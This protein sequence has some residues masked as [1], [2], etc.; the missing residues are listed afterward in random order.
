M[1][2]LMLIASIAMIGTGVFCVANGSVA[3]LTVAFVIGLMFCVMGALETVIGTRA[4][5]DV[6]ENAVSIIKDGVIMMIFGLIIISGQVTDDTTALMVFAMWLIIEGVL[7]FRA[8]NID[9]MHVTMEERVSIAVNALMLAAG[10]FM[11]FNISLFSLPGTLLIGIGMIILGLRRFLQS[12]SIEY[13]RP[14]FVTGNEEKLKEA[15]EEEKRALAKAKEGI[16]EQKNAQ[17]RIRK[18]REDIAAEQDIM[19]SAAIRR[20][21]RALERDEDNK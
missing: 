10:L 13:T 2:T 9:F 3:F 12:F 5:F 16:R 19:N 11:A 6:S 1:R 7:S 15:L 20:A 17:R 4:D 8:G 21:E 14:G 18:I